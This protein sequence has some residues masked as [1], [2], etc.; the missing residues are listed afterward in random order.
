MSRQF[1]NFMRGPVFLAILFLAN[2]GWASASENLCVEMFSKSAG[3]S[4]GSAV[5][6]MVVDRKR[7]EDLAAGFIKK[8]SRPPTVAA[9]IRGQSLKSM[10]S[11]MTSRLLWYNGH[12]YP[13]TYMRIG[14][15]QKIRFWVKTG[16]E[17]NGHEVDEW[18]SRYRSYP[19]DRMKLIRRTGYIHAEVEALKSLRNSPEAAF[20]IEVVVPK[21]EGSDSSTEAFTYNSKAQ[22]E[23][24]LASIKKAEADRF[25]GLVFHDLSN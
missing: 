10:L 2:I 4:M 11:S 12:T 19:D 23:S 18:I 5:R 20:P 24:E 6:T 14:I 9:R 3:D 13:F 15:P 7:A 8:F 16:D 17:A 1:R 22:I 21:P 25:D